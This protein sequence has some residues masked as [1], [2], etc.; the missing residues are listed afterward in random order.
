[1]KREKR[2]YRMGARAEAA[3]ATRRKLVDAMLALFVERPLDA[4]TLEAVASRAGVTLQPLLRR[5]GSKA[6]LLAAAA[7]DG[8]ARVAAQ[9]G[10]AKAGDV[11]DCVANLFEHY[12]AWGDVALRLVGQEERFEEIAAV[13]RSGR[14]MHAAWVERAFGPQLAEV[15]GKARV[16][17]RAS[18]VAACDVATWKVLRRD[19]GLSPR[20]AERA[21]RDMVEAICRG[22]E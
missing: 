19:V 20:D 11:A 10:Q 12:E 17:R 22:G 13:A 7:E 8:A 1:M 21:V 9:R 14:A 15:R 16:L 4:I 2:P 3:E 18:L 6:G 5:F